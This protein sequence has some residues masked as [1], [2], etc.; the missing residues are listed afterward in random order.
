MQIHANKVE[1]SYKVHV[2]LLHAS[3]TRLATPEAFAL[4]ESGIWIDGYPFHG[5]LAAGLS[6]STFLVPRFRF[7]FLDET[8]STSSAATWAANSRPNH[9]SSMRAHLSAMA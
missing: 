9:P 8:A 3:V 6:A 1:I 5:R 7:F 2:C 4:G